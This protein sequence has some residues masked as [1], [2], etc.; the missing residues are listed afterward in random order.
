MHEVGGCVEQSIR[1]GGVGSMG[2]DV[3]QMGLWK[4]MWSTGGR[5]A[6]VVRLVCLT[7]PTTALSVAL[8]TNT[9]SHR[10]FSACSAGS[11]SSVVVGMSTGAIN[12]FDRSEAG[13]W[14]RTGGP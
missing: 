8:P 7:L 1:S 12:V 2:G 11:A 4:A 10:A 9:D 6:W 14:T 5:G 13:V 3:H